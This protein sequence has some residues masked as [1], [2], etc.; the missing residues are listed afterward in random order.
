MQCDVT[1]IRPR[2]RGNQL[3]MMWCAVTAPYGTPIDVV[4]V[5]PRDSSVTSA[6][7]QQIRDYIKCFLNFLSVGSV[8]VHVALV[9]YADTATLEFD[10]LT[11]FDT[12]TIMN[13]IDALPLSQSTASDYLQ[14]LTLIQNSL[15]NSQLRTTNNVPAWVLFFADQATTNTNTA[16]I[17]QA[18][19][20]LK[21]FRFTIQT[22]GLNRNMCPN[23]LLNQM[24]TQSKVDTS[25][26]LYWCTDYAVPDTVAE[27][28]FFNECTCL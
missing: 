12:V 22:I 28:Q 18:T 8:A 11:N 6:A 2:C 7:S 15:S 3:M 10:Y 14:P 16:A 26:N 9:S 24:A 25:R 27:Q 23:S 13:Y 5:V 1:S 4:L 19:S 17:L 21:Q 20:N